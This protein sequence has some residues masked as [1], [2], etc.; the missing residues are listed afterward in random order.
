[1]GLLNFRFRQSLVSWSWWWEE[2]VSWWPSVQEKPVWGAPATEWEEQGGCRRTCR[3]KASM[4]WGVDQ[5]SS[6]Q[7]SP[8][9]QSCPLFATPWTAARQASLS[10][11]NSRSLP[12]LMSIELMMPSNHPIS[13]VPY[14]SCSQSSQN[15]D[16]FK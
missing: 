16:L 1:M 5:F 10:I 8:V 3:G 4:H 13:V 9:A 11:T 12:K 7:F 14:S 2:P 15:Q 6:V